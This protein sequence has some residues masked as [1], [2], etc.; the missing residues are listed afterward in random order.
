MADGKGDKV[1]T[2]KDYF[3]N[4]DADPIKAITA[5]KGKYDHTNFISGIDAAVRGTFTLSTSI[6]KGTYRATLGATKFLNDITGANKKI[7]TMMDTLIGTENTDNFF[8]Y[9]DEVKKDAVMM[10]REVGKQMANFATGKDKA[11]PSEIIGGLTSTAIKQLKLDAMAMSGFNFKLDDIVKNALIIDIETGGLFKDAPILQI[12]MGD[13]AKIE[14]L[15]KTV[16]ASNDSAALS[17][18]AAIGR[19]SPKEQMAEGFLSLNLMPEAIIRDVEDAP[20]GSR[21]ATFRTF[22]YIPRSEAE[23]K[24]RFGTWAS[25]KFP[26]LSEFYEEYGEGPSGSK[27]I[28]EA[29]IQELQ[30]Q[31]KK[32]GYLELKSGQ[33]VYSQKEGA[34][35]SMLFAKQASKEGR[36]LMAANLPYESFRVGKLWEHFLTQKRSGVADAFEPSLEDHGNYLNSDR[37]MSRAFGGTITSL[38]DMRSMLSATWKSE[39]KRNILDANNFFFTE[40]ARILRQQGKN[41]DVISLL[42]AYVKNVSA[43]LNTRDQLDL[44]KML[45]SGLMQTGLIETSGDLT[46]GTN[47][48][49]ASQV[50]LGFDE[51]HQALS[52]VMVQGRLLQEGKLPE[53]L[54]D[55]ANIYRAKESASA[56]DQVRSLF[57][58]LSI[59]GDEKKLGWLELAKIKD[60]ELELDEKWFGDTPIGI[61][62]GQLS[63]DATK[64]TIKGT[65]SDITRAYNLDK[66]LLRINETVDSYTGVA[67]GLYAPN[68]ANM[69][70]HS[71]TDEAGKL[72]TINVNPAMHEAFSMPMAVGRIKH[73]MVTATGAEVSVL[74]SQSDW[75]IQDFIKD[76]YTKELDEATRMHVDKRYGSGSFA[77]LKAG[78]MPIEDI[79]KSQLGH[80]MGTDLPV[81][82]DELKTVA[83]N[84]VK[85]TVIRRYAEGDNFTA[86]GIKARDLGSR[87]LDLKSHL[88]QENQA[89][90]LF[91]QDEVDRLSEQGIAVTPSMTEDEVSRASLAL[92]MSGGDGFRSALDTSLAPTIQGIRSRLNRGSGAER[93]ASSADF[94]YEA[95][96][97]RKKELVATGDYSTPKV[98]TPNYE[99]IGSAYN[100]AVSAK[101]KLK[102]GV[103]TVGS[104]LFSPRG[105]DSGLM[106]RI[107]GASPEISEYIM[108]NARRGLGMAGAAGA[109]VTGASANYMVDMPSYK[110][111][112]KDILK[113]SGDEREILNPED[114]RE[115][116]GRGAMRNVMTPTNTGIDKMNPAGF[117]VSAID[118]SKVDYAV[119]D[120]DTVEIISKG[121]MGLGRRNLGSVRLSGMDAPETAH[122][123]FGGPGEMP[124]AQRGKQ[125]LTNVLSAR[126]GAQ[127]VTGQGSTFGRS[128]GIV[129][130]DSGINYSYEMVNQGLATVLYRNTAQE[131]L[132][133]QKQFNAAERIARASDKGMFSDPFYAGVHTGIPGKERKGYNVLSPASAFK[134][135]FDRSPG[136][137]K[138]QAVDASQARNEEMTYAMDMSYN[139]YN[140][141][142]QSV[143]AASRGRKNGMADMQI[144]AMAGGLERNR[145]RR[146]ERR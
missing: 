15:K 40:Q 106:S 107:S 139:D 44:T 134:F 27:I 136:T 146:K 47:I 135:H 80:Q 76:E 66:E 17:A 117:A 143:N 4:P 93:L 38:R 59:L 32:E 22:S 26:W 77:A 24:Q 95:I 53:V 12:A 57:S 79:I 28:T 108:K 144:M 30:N 52:D 7:V 142:F 109:F 68:P 129:T 31:L 115:R 20:D 43:G 8:S 78:N 36:T 10:Y 67:E 42:P 132:V 87:L 110:P 73:T 35:H 133:N 86:R 118:S 46:S 51:A 14:E 72:Q 131:D 92:R 69:I 125:Y 88:H 71:Y 2:L 50:I 119:G 48:N 84:R 94:I 91:S 114:V 65:H 61:K 58:S 45:F 29:R 145:G 124:F 137:S 34:K 112:T 140:E 104:V 127:V 60:T 83:R 33:R 96:S 21:E 98:V 103:D 89:G 81:S 19:M 3:V 37:D 25:G 130:D 9:T 41:E 13:M 49:L 100:F 75:N 1:Y 116:G 64:G 85:S 70:T 138:Q 105:L 102:L 11:R 122:E 74:K 18:A 54:N 63:R 99:T 55:V 128:V 23:F 113:M 141:I 111:T 82:V 6:L 97:E 16:G 39:R 121:F 90:R 123:G 62:Q 126:T 56:L 5:L 120:A 101:D